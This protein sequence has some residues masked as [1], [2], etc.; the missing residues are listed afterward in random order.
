MIQ[1]VCKQYIWNI[2]GKKFKH[3]VYSILVKAS[4]FKLIPLTIGGIS[5]KSITT[6]YVQNTSASEKIYKKHMIL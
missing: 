1:S 3:R 2:T 6:T 4:G 5:L